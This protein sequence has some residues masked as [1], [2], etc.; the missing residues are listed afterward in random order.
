[1]MG[2]VDRV[3]GNPEH[4]YTRALLG[5]VPDAEGKK[6]LKPIDYA[7]LNEAAA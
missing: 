2:A 4:P 6:P 7:W 1:E 3:L 5:C